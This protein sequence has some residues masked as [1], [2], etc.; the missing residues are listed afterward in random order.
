MRTAV[1]TNQANMVALHPPPGI[2]NHQVNSYD[3]L[4]CS[5]GEG[6]FFDRHV[7]HVQYT[8]QV[9]GRTRRRNGEVVCIERGDRDVKI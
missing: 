8:T 9:K 2:Q 4:G 7:F 3:E 5:I 1:V 6:N